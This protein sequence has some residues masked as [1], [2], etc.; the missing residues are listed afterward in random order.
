[1]L[2]HRQQLTFNQLTIHLN[3]LLMRFQSQVKCGVKVH[4]LQCQITLITIYTTQ[5][6]QRSI[7]SLQYNLHPNTVIAFQKCKDY[8]LSLKTQ[9]KQQKLNS[10]VSIQSLTTVCFGSSTVTLSL[11][12]QCKTLT[13]IYFSDVWDRA[14]ECF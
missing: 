9:L 13:L 10:Y 12:M 7:Y 8:T 3:R 1:M 5:Q 6:K 2:V 14:H 4:V 11:K